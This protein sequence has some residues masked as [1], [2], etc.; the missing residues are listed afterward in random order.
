MAS[1]KRVLVTYGTGL[2][3]KRVISIPEG[4]FKD[5]DYVKRELSKDQLFANHENDIII[6]RFDDFFQENVELTSDDSLNH[7][8]KLTAET[9]EVMKKATTEDAVP[10]IAHGIL[11]N[12]QKSNKKLKI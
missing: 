6:L 2:V 9:L 8:D 5:V 3:R 7:G 4:S 1:S 12:P 10:Q 11:E